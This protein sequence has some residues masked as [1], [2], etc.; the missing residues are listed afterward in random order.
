[1]NDGS[2]RAR[3][4]PRS[5]RPV[6]KLAHYVHLPRLGGSINCGSHPRLHVE[7]DVA[8]AQVHDNLTA[9]RIIARI[10]KVN[11]AGEHGAIR[12]YRSQIAIARWRA[13]DQWRLRFQPS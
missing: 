1:M 8:N 4:Q 5:R 11:H 3:Y 2:G 12:I 10:L 7:A 9:A 6:F 13:P